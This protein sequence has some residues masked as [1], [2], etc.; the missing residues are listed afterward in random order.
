MAPNRV[1]HVRGDEP[2][3]VAFQ[4]LCDQV[5]PTCVGMNLIARRAM[6]LTNQVFPTCVG[7]NRCR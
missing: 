4:N 3:R 6:A 7:M 1:P 2:V 5:F